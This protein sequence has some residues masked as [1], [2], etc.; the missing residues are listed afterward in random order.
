MTY[1]TDY[2]IRDGKIYVYRDKG[3]SADPVEY[4][5]CEEIKVVKRRR[6]MYEKNRPI[7]VDVL[8]NNEPD[9]EPIVD[10]PRSVI[11]KSPVDYFTDHGLTI[12]NL[13]EYNVTLG[14]ILQDTEKAVPMK[15]EYNQLGY[16][17]HNKKLYY[18]ASSFYPET[19]SLCLKDGIATQSM[20]TF[21]SWR[22][23]LLPYVEEN[24]KLQLA[25][26]IAASAPVLKLLQY[27]NVMHDSM[28]FAYIGASST[29]KTL[30]MSLGCSV[31]G[32]PNTG[33]GMI[34]S[35]ID[36][37]NYFFAML[38]K[39]IGMAHFV[40]E[41]TLENRMDFTK[42]IYQVSMQHERGRLNGDGTPKETRKWVS[43]VIFTGECSMLDMTNG[44]AGLFARLVELNYE[45]TKDGKSADEIYNIVNENYG[46]AWLPLIKGLTELGKSGILALYEG[47]L[48]HLKSLI[49]TLSNVGNRILAKFAVLLTTVDVVQDAWQMNFNKEE[50]IQ[51]L[52]E[53]YQEIVK[54]DVIYDAYE[55]L[56]SHIVENGTLFPV[57]SKGEFSS[58]TTDKKH[59]IYSEY[60]GRKCVWMLKDKFEKFVRSIPNVNFDMLRRGFRDRG[61]IGY[62]DESYLRKQKI[63]SAEVSCYCIYLDYGCNIPDEKN[64]I[65]EKAKKAVVRIKSQANILLSEDAG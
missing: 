61:Y 12:S 41:A 40:D 47:N 22:D 7:V 65:K 4:E 26:A 39:K 54:G 10:I 53:R 2:E 46:T 30:A 62:F 1:F 16:I 63:G 49:A 48:K 9:A 42:Y 36:T 5:L 20:G 56:L 27:Y 6:L 31:F 29:G 18:A 17:E 28:L 55:T 37:E 32:N 59:G 64:E 15:Y 21:E 34:N 24:S 45:W 19:S 60:N 58:V 51:L 50:I 33:D 44:N 3:D 8:V 35:M 23:A 13:M 14:E 11:V 57:C 25:L 52:I 43:T 38:A